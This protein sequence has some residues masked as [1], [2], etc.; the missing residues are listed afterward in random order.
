MKLILVSAELIDF[1]P[2]PEAS[3]ENKA[4]GDCAAFLPDVTISPASGATFCPVL[5]EG[6]FLHFAAG[7]IE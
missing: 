5:I 3:L 1:L 2:S 6:V 4:F 7:E